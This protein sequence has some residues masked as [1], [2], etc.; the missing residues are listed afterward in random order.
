MPLIAFNLNLYSVDLAV[1]RCHVLRALADE[2]RVRVRAAR[3]GGI[4]EFAET[5]LH[6][7]S[8]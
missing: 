6:D 8:P 1:A 7:G 2:A 3:R 4:H 5:V